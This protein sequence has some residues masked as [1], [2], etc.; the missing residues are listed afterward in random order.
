MDE[1]FALAVGEVLAVA[2]IPTDANLG[3]PYF[4]EQTFHCPF[5]VVVFYGFHLHLALFSI[6][7]KAVVSRCAGR[8]D[9][10][11]VSGF[12]PESHLR[13]L[14]PVYHALRVL[15]VVFPLLPPPL[16]LCEKKSL[17]I[18]LWTALRGCQCVVVAVP[19]FFFWRSSIICSFNACQSSSSRSVAPRSGGS[20]AAGIFKYFLALIIRLFKTND[21]GKYAKR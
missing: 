2:K 9:L 21:R 16:A 12:A 13:S 20:V 3:E 19:S 1:P 10:C 15:C 11:L 8:Q 4:A 5:V 6:V 7:G 17:F 14:H 18:L